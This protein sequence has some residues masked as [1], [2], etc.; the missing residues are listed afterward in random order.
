MLASLR[1]RRR[2]PQARRARRVLLA[3]AFIW[4]VGL[5]DLHLTLLACDIGGFIE[6]NPIARAFI[7]HPAAV[8]AYKLV[9]M[10]SSTAVL[11]FYRRRRITEIGCWFLAA[12]YAALSFVWA[13]Y[14]RPF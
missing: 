9:L 5:A 2:D 4:I 13:A 7:A 10:S 11:A 8:I 3:L 14:Y 6:V 12:V 1:R